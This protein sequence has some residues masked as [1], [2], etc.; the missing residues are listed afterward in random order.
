MKGLTNAERDAVGRHFTHSFVPDATP[1]RININITINLE[2]NK[3]TVEDITR[4][5]TEVLNRNPRW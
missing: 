3:E 4:K 1:E 2:P 5:I